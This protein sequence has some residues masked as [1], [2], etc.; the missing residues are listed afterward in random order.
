MIEAKGLRASGFIA[1]LA[2]FVVL[3]AVAGFSSQVL[4]D[5]DTYTHIAAGQWMLD[6]RAVLNTD[7]FS[8]TF[9]GR[10]WQ[11]HEWLSE[12]L[13][14]LAYRAASWRGVLLLTGLAAGTAAAL[15]AGF[16]GRWLKGTALLVT[17]VLGLGCLTPSL[18]ARPHVLAAPFVVAWIAGLVSAREAGRAPSPWLLAIMVVWA[19]LHGGFVFGLAL[20][21]P[22]ALEAALA[23]GRDWSK[24][25]AQWVLFGALA[26]VASIV[27][28]H[29]VSNL[30]FPFRLMSLRWLSH[31]GEW[32]NANF[33]NLPP[34]EVAIL[35][36]VFLLLWRGVR[37]PVI[38]LLVVLGV[39]H[40]S[41]Q[42]ARNE[43]LFGIVAV[44]L[45]APSL[46]GKAAPASAQE[47]RAPAGAWISAG[48]ALLLCV[49]ILAR[50][51]LPASPPIG[52]QTALSKVP[53]DLAAQPMFNDYSFGGIL[54]FRG[55][56]PFINS[57]AELYGDPFL[58]GYGAM[59]VGN[60][61]A[62]RS[63]FDR[64][65]VEWTL[66]PPSSPVVA[67]LDISPGWRRLYSDPNAV[68]QTYDATANPGGSRIPA[69]RAPDNLGPRRRSRISSGRRPV[70][71]DARR[72]R[73][74]G[75]VRRTPGA[76]GP[77]LRRP[78]PAGAGCGRGARGGRSGGRPGWPWRRARGHTRHLDRGLRRSRTGSA[79]RASAA[80]DRRCR[81]DPGRVRPRLA[82]HRVRAPQR[83][84]SGLA[85]QDPG[86][87]GQCAGQARG[88]RRRRR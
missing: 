58:A 54:I 77:G 19:N 73:P 76:A 78:R 12:I 69:R 53:A 37:L 70:R 13:F 38:R 45:L 1:P 43:F 27:S 33:D 3:F 23:G 28:P 14:A 79:G 22:F 30:I 66:L 51:A 87:S 59:Q 60:L 71:D 74:A 64:Y 80:L 6:H 41:L 21:G 5:G 82:A 56:R 29:G 62:L 24:P 16:A 88:P 75:A 61:C 81:P 47:P 20:I 18:L 48:L 84:F 7:P 52:A 26:T 34:F 55:V 17:L 63:N 68:I 44:L 46:A 8:Y 39:L 31:I 49:E 42:H 10:P 65:G 4:A 36:G 67:I 57:R 35:A 50:L 2:A 32:S 15:V 72:R 9:A 25:L 85:S 86:L 83:R 11:T 40:I